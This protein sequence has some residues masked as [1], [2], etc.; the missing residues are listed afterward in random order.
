MAA[1]N[2]TDCPNEDGFALELTDVV[3]VAWL[4][5]CERIEE[6]LP[7]KLASPPYDPLIE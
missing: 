5:V 6:A 3:V 7:V 4:T 1:V 2:V